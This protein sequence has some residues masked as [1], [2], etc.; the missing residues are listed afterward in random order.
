MSLRSKKSNKLGI[1]WNLIWS[2]IKTK[3]G[4]KNKRGKKSMSFVK[5][6]VFREYL[7]YLKKDLS[8]CLNSMLHKTKNK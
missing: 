5:V 7:V 3:E 8:K 1:K 2:L 6:R 4:K